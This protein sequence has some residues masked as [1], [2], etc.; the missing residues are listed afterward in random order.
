MSSAAKK[1]PEHMTTAEFLRWEG[2]GTDTKYELVDGELVAMS[3][4]T[5]THGRIQARVC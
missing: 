3:L 1:L 2:D 5:T 4:A